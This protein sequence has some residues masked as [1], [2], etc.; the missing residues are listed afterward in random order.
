MHQVAAEEA[1]QLVVEHAPF[2]I[3]QKL[4]QWPGQPLTGSTDQGQPVRIGLSERFIGHCI[5]QPA[6]KF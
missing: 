2:F 4:P 3:Q 1:P 6:K 5:L